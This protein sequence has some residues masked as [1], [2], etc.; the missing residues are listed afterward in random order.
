MTIGF[1]M[2]PH[3]VWFS[4]MPAPKTMMIVRTRREVRMSKSLGD[5][6]VSTGKFPTIVP[7]HIGLANILSPQYPTVCHPVRNVPIN[8]L[9]QAHIFPGSFIQPV[10]SGWPIY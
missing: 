2:R 6:L 3:L 1:R 10:V 8:Q 5:I 4:A 9:S 7:S